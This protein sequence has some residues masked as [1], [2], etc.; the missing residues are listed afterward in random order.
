[1]AEMSPLNMQFSYPPMPQKQGMGP[2]MRLAAAGLLFG[3]MVSASTPMQAPARMVPEAPVTNFRLPMFDDEGNRVWHLQGR[4][5]RY[6]GENEVA[7]FDMRLRVFS[8]EEPDRVATE[9]K[10]PRA[11]MHIGKN[12]GS[13][14]ESISVRGDHYLVTGEQWLWD[15]DADRVVIER[16]VKVVFFEGLSQVLSS[17]GDDDRAPVSADAPG[18]TPQTPT[19]IDSRRLEL[20]IGEGETRFIF[21]D[22]VNVSSSDLNVACE[23]LDVFTS[24]GDI[25]DA[26]N[27]LAAGDALGMGRIQR[28]YA[29]DNVRVTRDGVEATAGQAKLFPLEER[30][31]LTERPLVRNTQGVVSGEIIT[32]LQGVNKAIVERPRV[33]LAALPRV[34]HGNAAEVGDAAEPGGIRS[35]SPT[36]IVSELLEMLTDGD[37]TRFIFSRDVHVTGDNIAVFSDRIEVFTQA[38]GSE[39][40]VGSGNDDFDGVGRI[41]RILATGDV[42]IAQEGSEATSGRAEF[43]PLEGNM[44]LTENPMIRNEQGT[45]SGTRITLAQNEGRAR[46]ERPR[47]T[48]AALPDFGPGLAADVEDANR[49]AADSDAING[50]ALSSS[51]YTVIDGQL[52]EMLSDEAETRF[53]FSNEVRVTGNNLAVNCERLEVLSLRDESNGRGDAASTGVGRIQLILATGNVRIAQEGREANAGRAEFVPPEGRIVLTEDPVIR[54]AQGSVMGERILLLR[55]ENHAIVERPRVLLPVRSDIGL[56]R[57]RPEPR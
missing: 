30:I 40:P 49:A 48:L 51:T 13:G 34:T 26:E 29:I 41:Q 15:G 18:S 50:A 46:V 47:V 54:D 28:I 21:S 45:V 52:L 31:V 38:V 8:R 20:L 10:S 4:E 56:G 14:D 32:L 19:V 12:T 23:R 24:R 22:D 57:G 17:P 5:G 3:F 42:R 11:A 44:V 2:G 36:V 33:E 25:G 35:S 55:G 1:M 37:E 27:A 9:I 39:R 7:V 53:I 43:F 6:L 16:N